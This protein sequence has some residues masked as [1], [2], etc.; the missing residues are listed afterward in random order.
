M[1]SKQGGYM[2]YGNDFGMDRNRF[3]YRGGMQGTGDRG[4]GGGF[5]PGMNRGGP[6]RG[7][8]G[9]Y[10]SYS[11]RD[12]LTNQG[13]FS[14]HF[15]GGPDYGYEATGRSL[16]R[17]RWPETSQGGFGFGYRGE[18][19]GFGGRSQ[20]GHFGR[21]A[22]YGPGY[23]DRWETTTPYDIGYRNFRR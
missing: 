5:S 14:D 22:N 12:F 7:R 20:G 11:R 8:G 6:F 23:G 4:F 21:Q 3:G 9:E 18:S 13:D 2:R 16:G 17:D 10:E 19:R 1:N 15:G